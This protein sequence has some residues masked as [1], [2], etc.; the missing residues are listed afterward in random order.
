MVHS[1]YARDLQ[2]PARSLRSTVLHPCL[3]KER[4]TAEESATNICDDD[5]SMS[6]GL[7][8]GID[9]AC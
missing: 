6:E 2:G 8:A 3:S 7:C 4:W 5:K 9:V 1:V